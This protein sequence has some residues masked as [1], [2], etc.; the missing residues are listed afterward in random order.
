MASFGCLFL[1]Q[2]AAWAVVCRTRLRQEVVVHYRNQVFSCTSGL[3]QRGLEIG[4]TINRARALFPKAQ[5]FPRERGI[6]EIYWEDLLH[7][8]RDCTPQ[9]RPLEDFQLV[10]RWV[11]VQGFDP[12]R[13]QRVICEYEAYAATAAT[14]TCAMVAATGAEPGQLLQIDR[15]AQLYESIPVG[16]LRFFGFDR[17]MLEFFDLLG[18][19]ALAD[20]QALTQRQLVAQFRD[21][22]RRLFKL[23]HPG[24]TRPLANR[25]D[26]A[27]TCSEHLE[28]ELADGLQLEE[29]TARL[30][31]SALSKDPRC[32][33]RLKLRLQFRDGTK[34]A[35]RLLKRP[36]RRFDL[37][38]LILRGLVE[39]LLDRPASEITGLAVGL[40]SLVQPESVQEDLFRP[41]QNR[42]FLHSLAKRFPGKVHRPSPVP[43]FL[44]ERAFS[45]DPIRDEQTDPPDVRPPSR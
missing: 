2:F 8:L 33:R 26:Q 18:F 11:L 29:A 22:G 32:A 39:D 13:L 14:P 19:R 7:Q 21:S 34:A 36:T 27:V 24:P 10:G 20:L 4:E 3:L 28:W 17:S 31:R 42:P 16:C 15:M 5:F 35:C 1:P 23:L 40:G 38:M 9:V 45:L 41:G 25:D 30:L 37:L 44:P 6:E 12:G 43:A